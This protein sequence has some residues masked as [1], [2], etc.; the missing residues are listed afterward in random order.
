MESCRAQPRSLPPDAN[1]Q[2]YSRLLANL[3]NQNRGIGSSGTIP[4][5]AQTLKTAII[6]ETT[7]LLNC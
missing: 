5:Y 1:T 3:I 6:V 4:G 7:E 2:S